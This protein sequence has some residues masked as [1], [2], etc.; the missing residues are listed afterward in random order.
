MKAL[1]HGS[2]KNDESMRPKKILSW[3]GLV[4]LAILVLIQFIPG[5]L[6]EVKTDVPND[7]LANNTVNDSVASILKSS[8]YD[9]HSL[10]TNYPWYSQVAPVK[11]LVA[12]DTRVGREALNFSEWEGLSIRTKMKLLA[13]IGEEVEHK[14]MPMPIYLI[15]HAEARL[16]VEERQ[17]IYSWAENYSNQ[18]LE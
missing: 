12:Y 5:K 8:C 1:N 18:L 16:S 10:E 11:W 4:L 17:L 7:F 3:L 14:K 6:P 2:R 13:E 15:T 9:C